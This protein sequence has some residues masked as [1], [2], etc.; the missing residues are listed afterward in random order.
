MQKDII[1][2]LTV[3]SFHEIL[4]HNPGIICLKFGATWCGPCKLIN[5][6]VHAF[7]VSSPI[8]V[9]CCD[10]DVDTSYEL[11][12]HL[13]NKKMLNGIPALLCY[14]RGNLTYIPDD[15]VVGSD[16][17]QLHHFFKRVGGYAYESKRNNVR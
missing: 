3:S 4:N 17:T 12:A 8:E 2:E 1:T 9:M 7:F 10:I 13:K 14:K 16:A 5:H 11:Y 15:S 6:S